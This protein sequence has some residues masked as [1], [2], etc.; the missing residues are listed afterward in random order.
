LADVYLVGFPGDNTLSK[1]EWELASAGH[2]MLANGNMA[3]IIAGNA[4]AWGYHPPEG[5]WPRVMNL[6]NVKM[7]ACFHKSTSGIVQDDTHWIKRLTTEV[8]WVGANKG[9]L[10]CSKKVTCGDACKAAIVQDYSNSQGYWNKLGGYGAYG[11]KWR[12]SFPGKENQNYECKHGALGAIGPNGG[13]FGATA[14]AMA[15]LGA[16]RSNAGAFTGAKA[17]MN[18]L[19]WPP[20]VGIDDLMNIEEVRTGFMSLWIKNAKANNFVCN[21][22]VPDGHGG[23]AVNAWDHDACRVRFQ[24]CFANRDGFL[25]VAANL[26]AQAKLELQENGPCGDVYCDTEG[27]SGDQCTDASLESGLKS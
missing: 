22:Y 23:A 19:L 5:V 3:A 20:L 6:F 27:C 14:A 12:Y 26:D 18:C 24:R 9:W 10:F 13:M 15:N 1:F 17:C 7:A 8:K 2:V 21:C 25:E 16:A 4:N 11:G